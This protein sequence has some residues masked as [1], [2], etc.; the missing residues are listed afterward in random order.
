MTLLEWSRVGSLKG[1][2]I[3]IPVEE[4]LYLEQIPFWWLSSFR[5]LV[6]IKKSLLHREVMLELFETLKI[7]QI[8]FLL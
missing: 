7:D 4:L 6:C 3:L 5:T 8:A 1:N 2:K